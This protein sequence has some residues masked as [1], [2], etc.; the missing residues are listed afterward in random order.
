[1][2]YYKYVAIN[3]DGKR[4]KGKEYF[5]N[6]VEFLC[7]IRKKG[8]YIVNSKIVHMVNFNNLLSGINTK[9]IAIFAKQLSSMLY[10]GFNISEALTII[11]GQINNKQLKSNIKSIEAEVKKGSSFY[12]SIARYESIFPK[13]YIEMINIGEQGGRLDTVLKSIY[14]YY[15]NEYKMK[16]KVISAMIYPLILLLTTIFI[17][18]YLE[19]NV[20]PMFSDIFTNLGS[21]LPVYSKC[22]M[23]LSG[24]IKNNLHIVII[25]LIFIN[26]AVIII[27]CSEKL[28]Y[29]RDKLCVLLPI[30]GKL[31]KKIIGV[32]F[33]NCLCLLQKSGVD[34][35]CALQ[36]GS[37]VINNSYVEKEIQNVLSNIKNGDCIAETLNLIGIFPDFI[38]SMI[39]LG[40]H[41]GNLEEMLSIASQIYSE[42]I[43][44]NLN[45][46]V[47]LL[48]PL[49]IVIMALLIG[50][51]V[52]SIMVPMMKMMQNV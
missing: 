22:L 42:D 18:F 11:Y 13:F 5:E 37:K 39:S 16:K 48:E 21:G 8:Y 32:K 23:L 33:S 50:T 7:S 1:M 3:N 14:D 38:I 29:T 45:K 20:I 28:K 46:A 24:S 51:I 47:S 30:I 52:M 10:A 35:I 41:G 25:L 26:T 9:D 19:I 6:E 17:L 36:M 2:A 49:I 4:I 34:I 40:E 43:E 27:F 44:D 12:D 15:I 31:N